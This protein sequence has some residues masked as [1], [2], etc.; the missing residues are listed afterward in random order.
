MSTSRSTSSPDPCSPAAD[1]RR[2][3]RRRPRAGRRRRDRAR[4][5]ARPAACAE[6]AQDERIRDE[7]PRFANRD[8]AR[9][10]Q[11]PAPRPGRRRQL[12]LLLPGAWSEPLPIHCWAV[13]HDGSLLLVDAGET[14]TARTC[15]S[16]AS[17]SRSSRSCPAPSPAR[18]RAADVS[19]SRA[20]SPSQRPHRRRRPHLARPVRVH[21]V[22]LPV[23]AAA[24]SAPDAPAAAPALPR[25]F[26][27]N[28]RARGQSVR[29]LPA[30][31]ALSDE[32]TSS[33]S[34]RPVTPPATSR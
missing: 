25:G 5:R 28:R 24:V 12:D 10:A 23:P 7:D 34:A 14:A 19:D 16:R 13:E 30:A 22:E 9:Q 3:N 1:H 33:P 31:V 26:A 21:D 27:R 2:P 11:L 8:R 20:H 4:L 15:P 18:D 6:A 29:P 32:G 17:T